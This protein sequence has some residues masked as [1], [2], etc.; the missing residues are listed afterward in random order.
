VNLVASSEWGAHWNSMEEISGFPFFRTVARYLP[1]KEGVDFFEIGYGA[2]G[3]LAQFCGTLGY[4]AHGIEFATDPT[5][6]EA[7][8]VS[9]GVSIGKLHHGDFEKWRPA[10]RY[11]VVA[12]FGFVEHFTD[13]NRIVDRHFELVL[14]GGYVVVG[15]PNFARGQWLLHKLFD[16]EML[17]GHNVRCMNLAFLRSA[18]NRNNAT[19]IMASYDGGHFSFWDSGRTRRSWLRER[20]MWRVIGMAKRAASVVPAGSNSILSPYLLAVY[21]APS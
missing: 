19:L 10:R 13:A 4:T 8:L 20:L 1:R 15:L 12:S 11:E 2:G 17:K 7:Y 6:V 9:K 3:I 21:R 5:R 16:W 14:P 18:A